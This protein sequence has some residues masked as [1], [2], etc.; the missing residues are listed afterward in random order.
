MILLFS[1][2]VAVL[3]GT[4]AFLMLKADLFRVVVG[5]VMISNAAILALIGSGLSRG[6]APIHPLPDERL[7]D[8]LVQAMA[9]TAI[10]IGFAVTALLLAIAYRVYTS[11]ESVDLDELSREEFRRE[12]ELEREEFSP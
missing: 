7:S 9:L 6:A 5:M 3:F 1:G 2:V 11:H 12:R 4:G 10:V 8:P